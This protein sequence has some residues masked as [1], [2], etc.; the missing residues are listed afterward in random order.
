MTWSFDYDKKANVIHILKNDSVFLTQETDT[1]DGWDKW[2]SKEDAEKWAKA[3]VEEHEK[4][5][6]EA[7]AAFEATV[8]ANAEFEAAAAAE[9]E[10]R[11][12]EFEAAEA[13]KAKA[14]EAEAK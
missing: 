4:E 1:T 14:E 10:K 8:K 7:K 12:A 2:K 11:I 3:F 6:A 9:A 13:A 5:D